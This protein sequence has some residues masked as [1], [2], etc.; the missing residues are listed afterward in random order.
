MTRFVQEGKIG[1]VGIGAMT[2]MVA[3]A[4]R[5]ANAVRAA[6]VPVVMGGGQVTVEPGEAL[7]RGGGL[8]DA[9]ASEKLM[10]HGRRSVRM[11]RGANSGKSINLRTSLGRNENP[12]CNGVRRSLGDP[13]TWTN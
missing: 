5:M 13:W 8:A 11:L 7:G 2:R 1:L 4:Y 10:K 12:R 3:K 9:L 6:G